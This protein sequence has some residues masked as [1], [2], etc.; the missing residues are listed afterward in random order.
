VTVLPA[1]LIPKYSYIRGVK[2]IISKMDQLDSA[3]ALPGL[4]TINYLGNILAKAEAERNNSYD[5]VFLRK[6]KEI[7]EFTTAN[8]FCVRDGA[9]FTPRLEAGILPGITR[10]QVIKVLRRNK[11]TVS[12]KKLNVQEIPYMEEVFMTSS[13]RGILPVVQI[14]KNPVGNGKVGKLTREISRIYLEERQK[15]RV[16][17]ERALR[18]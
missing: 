11:Y 10:S 12:E 3:G 1:P 14:D 13:L 15:S 8:F 17:F 7:T 5:A 4:K 2:V 16:E 18:V 6:N 9:F